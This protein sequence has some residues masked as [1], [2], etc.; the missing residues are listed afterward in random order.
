[1]HGQNHTHEKNGCARSESQ[2]NEIHDDTH[3]LFRN[4]QALCAARL[5]PLAG[6]RGRIREDEVSILLTGHHR[7]PPP[8]TPVRAA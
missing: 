2:R 8:S 1:M 6:V 7:E 4:S 5:L 3:D